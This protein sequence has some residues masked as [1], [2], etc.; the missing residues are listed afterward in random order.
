M[1]SGK[2]AVPECRAPGT[3]ERD[4]R[5]EHRFGDANVCVR[6]NQGLLRLADVRPPL[7]QFRRQACGQL[8]RQILAPRPAFRS[9]DAQGLSARNAVRIFSQKD[10]DGVLRL[11]ALALQVRA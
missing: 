7:K 2:L 5:E 4:L 8:R 10:V 3:E 11:A 9:P 6:S 1:R